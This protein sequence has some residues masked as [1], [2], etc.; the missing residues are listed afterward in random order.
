MRILHINSNFLYSKIYYNQLENMSKEFNHTIF[1]PIKK[2]NKTKVYSKYNVFKPMIITKLD[3]LLTYNRLNKCFEYIKKNLDLYTFDL[4]HAHTLS[5]DGLLARKL[6]KK[7]GTPY[8]VTVRNTDINFTLKYKIHLKKA[9]RDI[10]K[11]ASQIIFP[12]KVYESK[13]IEL[14]GYEEVSNIVKDKSL[15]IPNGVDEFWHDNRGTIKKL[16]KDSVKL[17]YVGRIYQQKNLENVLRAIK[18]YEK[19]N[20]LKVRFTIIGPVLD[21]NYFNKL[22]KKYKFDYIK[23][24]S[25]EDIRL[26]MSKHDIFI[27]PSRNETF[28]LVYIEALSQFLPIIYTKNEG[29][30]NYFKEGTFGYSSDPD[31]INSIMESLN[32]VIK[33][34]DNIQINIENKEFLRQFNWKNIGEKYEEVYKRFRM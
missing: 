3:S 32:N 15:V 6:N 18:V 11:N 34:Y 25:K 4:I 7:Y 19:N 2:N 14:L 1:N 24:L 29:V 31:D 13:L 22:R 30:Y 26:Q 5:N 10:I 28:G 17:I 27:M 16:Q 23:E 9:Y 12:N 21:F 20:K 8:L 33:N